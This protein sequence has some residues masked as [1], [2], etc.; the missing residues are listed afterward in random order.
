MIHEI[1]KVNLQNWHRDKKIEIAKTCFQLYQQ[2]GD[3]FFLDSGMWFAGKE[4]RRSEIEKEL[5]V[6][7]W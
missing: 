3:V 2:F 1:E 5:D 7:G 4:P 6:S